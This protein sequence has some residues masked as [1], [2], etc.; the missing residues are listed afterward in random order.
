VK[1]LLV[2]LL[3][4]TESFRVSAQYTFNL[5]PTSKKNFSFAVAEVLNESE[6]KQAWIGEIYNPNKKK[7]KVYIQKG[8]EQGLLEY[9]EKQNQSSADKLPIKLII[10]NIYLIE[11][12]VDNKIQGNLKFD[13]TAFS[14]GK[15]GYK[16]LCNSRNSGKYT[17][18]F[19]KTNL[20]NIQ[21]QFQNALDGAVNFI[22][23]YIQ[24]NQT[25]LELFA[26]NSEIIILPF[27]TKNSSDTLYFQQR[28]VNWNDFRGPI[29]SQTRYG[30]AIFTSF[31]FD[32]QIT[33]ENNTIKYFIT[34]YVFTDKN[35]SWAKPEIKNSYSLKHEQL[36]FDICYLMALKFLE[37]VKTFKEPTI[38]D[39][40]S[41]IQ[42]EY[43][44]FYR[45]THNLQEKYDAETNHSLIKD[46]QLEWELK[47]AEEIKGMEGKINP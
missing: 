34:P 24:K 2:C 41:R 1:I 42:Y 19:D 27:K 6:P 30:A 17:R 33:V 32:S 45:K 21:L 35:M 40:R 43:L 11:T 23:N 9:F 15:N 31:G 5:K 8:I 25:N 29:R 46:K 7:E 18:N 39:L 12:L 44:E 14:L 22:Q 38:D 4:L 36:H 26:R 20:E 28:K 16:A 47:I 13:I 3:I 37:T 10:K